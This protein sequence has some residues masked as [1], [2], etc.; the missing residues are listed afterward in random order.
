MPGSNLP[1]RVILGGKPKAGLEF[2]CGTKLESLELRTRKK[3]KS[4]PNKFTLLRID[5]INIIQYI[6]ESVLHI[7]FVFFIS[8][9]FPFVRSRSPPQCPNVKKKNK[10]I[11]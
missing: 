10:A 5:I 1:S 7:S 4:Y 9:F 11:K 6:E 8:F 2:E 3:K